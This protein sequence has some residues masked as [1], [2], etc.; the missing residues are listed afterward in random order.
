MAGQSI[1]DELRE[2][3][4]RSDR[5]EP[6]GGNLDD[7][8]D[9]RT[10]AGCGRLILGNEPPVVEQS[11]S[12][13]QNDTAESDGVGLIL[14]AGLGERLG[15]GP[16]AF[17][18]IDGVSV[19]ARAVATFTTCVSRVIVGVPA[20]LEQQAR[21]DLG[22]SAEVIVGGRS[23]HET[24]CRLFELSSESLVV[25]H[26]AARPFV[27][28]D[29]VAE[30]ISV[31]RANGAAVPFYAT[32]VASACIDDGLIS[33]SFPRYQLQLAQTPQAFRREVLAAAL[34]AAGDPLQ[35]HPTPWELVLATG[36]P[37]H[38]V[39]GEEM[40]IKITTQLDWK[41]ATEVIAPMRRQRE[42]GYDTN[43]QS[44]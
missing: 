9:E 42:G 33:E 22:N 17:L 39:A 10:H 19:V 7:I 41:I 24:I 28:T 34:N 20:E 31:A 12:A 40:N 4:T 38:A 25:I 37:V 13:E 30:V 1:P 26:D 29:L 11:M 2:C 3:T 35:S 36:H 23:R 16:K 32:R 43:R 18:Q 15:L 27:S 5:F 8:P 21:D 44:R 14:A 6:G